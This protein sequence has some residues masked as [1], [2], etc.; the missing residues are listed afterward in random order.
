[1]NLRTLSLKVLGS[2]L[3]IAALSSLSGCVVTARTRPVR[4]HVYVR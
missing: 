1:M 4:A 3:A 2:L